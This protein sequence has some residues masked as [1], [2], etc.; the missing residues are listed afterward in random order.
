M[1]VETLAL[2]AGV[3]AC[4]YLLFG[5]TG[6]GSTA[7]ALPLLVHFIP[8]RYLVPLL[9]LLDLLASL[10]ISLRARRGVR[11]DELRRVVPAMAVGSVL[12]LALLVFAPQTPLLIALGVLLVSYSAYAMLRRGGPPQVSA[13]WGPPAGF[14]SGAL[15]AL[16]GNGG[17]VMAMY[18]G[19]RIRDKDGLRGTA[20]AI[21]VVNAAVR[22]VLFAATGL[23]SQEGLLTA[24]A[25]LIP[26]VLVGLA[27]GN[28]LHARVSVVALLR[29]IYVIIAFAGVSL[30]VREIVIY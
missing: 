13:A 21:V 30:L 12:G 6:F 3:V 9:S 22:T 5:L 20:S 8:L 29:V 7:L 19:A 23:L 27:L 10:L 16:Y 17:L 28:L 26:S 18:I 25:W 1:P 15:A 11:W 4:T 2:A 24:A 14:G